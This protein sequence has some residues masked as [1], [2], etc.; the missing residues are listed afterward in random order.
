MPFL[1]CTEELPS[2]LALFNVMKGSEK[3]HSFKYSVR[4]IALTMFEISMI[5]CAVLTSIHASYCLSVCARRNLRRFLLD[6]IISKFL[7]LCP[8]VHLS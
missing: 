5:I 3:S 8:L 4:V 2:I 6:H 7:E 1:R